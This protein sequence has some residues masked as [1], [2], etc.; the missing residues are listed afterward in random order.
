MSC[1]CHDWINITTNKINQVYLKDG[2]QWDKINKENSI[3]NK[4]LSKVC[5]QFK[6][7]IHFLKIK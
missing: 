5:L 4:T 1:N 2:S 7:I 3:K 6:T